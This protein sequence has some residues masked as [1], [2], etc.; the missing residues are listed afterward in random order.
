LE[1]AEAL[2]TI[3]VIG[4]TLIGLP[5]VQLVI[6]LQEEHPTRPLGVGHLGIPLRLWE[7][8]IQLFQ[9]LIGQVEA[10]KIIVVIGMELVGT[11]LETHPDLPL[12][13]RHIQHLE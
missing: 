3:V 10:L 2:K 8:S 9:P 11:P 13:V 6:L 7:I 1:Q 5:I 12:E 4:I